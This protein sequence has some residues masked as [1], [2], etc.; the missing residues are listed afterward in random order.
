[1]DSAFVAPLGNLYLPQGPGDIL[2][3][4]SSGSFIVLPITFM[5][6]IHLKLTVFG[7]RKRLRFSFF[8]KDVQ[9]FQHHY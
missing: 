6:A 4:F 7:M 2:L 5:C 1:M 9:L 3:M 8:C